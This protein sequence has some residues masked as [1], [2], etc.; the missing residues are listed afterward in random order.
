MLPRRVFVLLALALACAGEDV[1]NTASPAAAPDLDLD[2]ALSTPHPAGTEENMSESLRVLVTGFNDWKDLGD[3]PNV[4]RCRDNPSCRLLLG[5]ETAARP[6]THAGPLVELL[7][8]HATTAEG[9]AITWTFGTMPVTWGVADTVPDYDSYDVVVHVGLGVYDTFSVLKLEDGAFNQRKGTDAAGREADEAIASGSGEVLD[10]PE[11][12]DIAARVRSLDGHTFGA[13]T[14]QVAR[15]RPENSY[16]CNETH[17][18]ALERVDA[19]VASGGRLRHAYFL[20]IPYAEEDDYARL[21]RGVA[22]VVI[23]LVG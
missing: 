1:P 16:L 17:F 7:T 6:D 20:H 5:D 23:A 8:G 9:R 13:Y 22:G 19:S 18:R 4:W 2:I 11:G 15:A 21:A 12:T 14:L 10:A 3:P